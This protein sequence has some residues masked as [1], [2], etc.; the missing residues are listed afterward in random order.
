MVTKPLRY[1]PSPFQF[2]PA[3]QMLH[4]GRYGQWQKGVVVTDAFNDVV[5]KIGEM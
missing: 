1:Q 5:K 4:V 2:N 3:N